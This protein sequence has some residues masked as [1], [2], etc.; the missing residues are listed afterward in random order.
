[1]KLNIKLTE[2]STNGV[3]VTPAP[4]VICVYDPNTP[5]GELVIDSKWLVS[6]WTRLGKSA[7]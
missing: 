7:Q 6:I 1:M 2:N 4:G 3:L 5:H